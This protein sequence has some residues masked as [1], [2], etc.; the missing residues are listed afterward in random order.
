MLNLFR[1]TLFVAVAL[2][3]VSQGL[4]LQ[5]IGTC[6]TG[7]R[8]TGFCQNV[9][10]TP[11]YNAGVNHDMCKSFKAAINAAVCAK[12]CHDACVNVDA[13]DCIEYDP[14]VCVKAR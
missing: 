7:T 12:T 1:I 6:C 9:S 2:V 13:N 3:T 4:T 11:G 8:C 5:R 10:I 14:I